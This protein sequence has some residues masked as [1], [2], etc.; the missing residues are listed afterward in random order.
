MKHNKMINKLRQI[1]IPIKNLNDPFYEKT[2]VLMQ[3][4]LSLRNQILF[5]KK[6]NKFN[7]KIVSQANKIMR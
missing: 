4:M 1:I 7:N 3:L 2:R 5:H 6:N